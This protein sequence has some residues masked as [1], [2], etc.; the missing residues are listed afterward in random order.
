MGIDRK[1]KE[2]VWKSC[3]WC[4]MD[5]SVCMWVHL[6]DSCKASLAQRG[7]TMALA[8][9][10]NH[11][12]HLLDSYSA[13]AEFIPLCQNS[14][15]PCLFVGPNHPQNDF[16]PFFIFI[17][18][19]LLSILF[20]IVLGYA[21]RLCIHLH[22]S[23]AMNIC[24]FPRFNKACNDGDHDVLRDFHNHVGGGDH[25]E[26][27]N[28]WKKKKHQDFQPNISK[29]RFALCVLPLVTEKLSS[30]FSSLHHIHVCCH[31]LTLRF[32]SCPMSSGSFSKQFLW[33]SKTW[34]KADVRDFK[35]SN[36]Q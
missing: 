20:Q 19:R 7:L 12:S 17:F 4:W 10:E 24:F 14:E 2:I 34:N 11:I 33:R 5:M 29:F 35:A 27:I 16:F 6:A 3:E 8:H 36:C 21:L 13:S 22:Y 25:F 30:I 18:T 23:K 31:K 28:F 1:F 9:T 32:F 26:Y 15:I